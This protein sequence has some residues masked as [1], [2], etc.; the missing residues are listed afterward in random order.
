MCRLGGR[1]GERVG[2]TRRGKVEYLDQFQG[3]ELSSPACKYL[4]NDRNIYEID[5]F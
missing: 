4:L 5:E 3:S 1:L 2:Q